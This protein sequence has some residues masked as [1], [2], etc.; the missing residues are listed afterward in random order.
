[1]TKS[2]LIVLSYISTGFLEALLMNIPVIAF[3]NTN[4]MHLVEEYST[5][6]DQLAEVGIIQTSPEGASNFVNKIIDNPDIW[7]SSC[8]VQEAK[9]KFLEI[10]IGEPSNLFDY[11]IKLN[12][13]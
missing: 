8:Q 10:N 11:I 1:M 4:S 7:W 9:K 3:F 12:K 13:Y 5:F 2:K 6:F